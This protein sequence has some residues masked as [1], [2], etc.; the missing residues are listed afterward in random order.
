MTTPWQQ[1]R[2]I[3]GDVLPL[4]AV[5]VPLSAAAGLVLAEDVV[6]R[7]DLPPFTASA[8]DGWAIRGDPPWAIETT[9]LL[10][11]GTARATATGRTLPP[12]TDAVLRT[13]DADVDPAA[14]VL[15]QRP[16]A[17]PPRAGQDIRSRG[18]ECLAGDVVAQRGM[19]CVPAVL[20]LVAAAGV[21]TVTVIVRPLVDVLVQGDEL[22]SEGVPH[23]RFVR[24]AL[25]PML[26]SWL[27]TL[28]AEAATPQRVT[29]TPEA[30]TDAIISSTADLIVTTG[31]TASGPKDHLHTVLATLGADLLAD[32]VDVRP[33]H[34]MLLA[35]LPDGRR[36]VGLPGNPLAAVSGL[37]T[38][39]APAVLALAGRSP[40]PRRTVVLGSAVVG[41]PLDVRLVP[42]REGMPVHHVGPAM[43]RG[44]ASADALAV[45]PPG[46]AEAGTQVEV[47][48]LP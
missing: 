2:S 45:V 13:E 10:L 14:G 42:V 7:T 41:H 32:G 23:G 26:P 24:D 37:L 25:G 15:R 6:A 40:Q 18:T 35:R 1:A 16:G 20:G 36:L 8:M 5:E 27:A 4:A 3:A 29:D 46:G 22:L 28:G 12:G 34:P 19:S 33:G 48:P 43:L 17:Q 44:L 47:L 11:P 39:V 31:S 21:D 9:P 38:L 30:L